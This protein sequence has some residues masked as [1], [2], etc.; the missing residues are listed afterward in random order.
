[1]TFLPPQGASIATLKQ[2]C[3]SIYTRNSFERDKA[4]RQ[5]TNHIR[6]SSN[7]LAKAKYGPARGKTRVR[8]QSSQCASRMRHDDRLGEVAPG[9]LDSSMASLMA[10]ALVSLFVGKRPPAGIRI[11]SNVPQIPLLDLT[12]AGLD[13]YHLKV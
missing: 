13:M 12:S 7:L 2:L 4:H 8:D 1:M 3:C 5:G 10:P 6:A 11:A 9:F